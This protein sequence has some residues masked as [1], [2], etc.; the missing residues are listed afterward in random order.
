M[1]EGDRETRGGGRSVNQ[2]YFITTKEWQVE[3]CRQIILVQKYQNLE[4]R[5]Y[6]IENLYSNILPALFVRLDCFFR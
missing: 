6:F 1:G 2:S 4:L 5:F 3:N